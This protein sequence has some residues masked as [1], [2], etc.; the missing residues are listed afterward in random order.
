MWFSLHD[1]KQMS[2]WFMVRSD[3]SN[4]RSRRNIINLLFSNI[5]LL[6]FKKKSNVKNDIYIFSISFDLREMSL[7]WRNVTRS[8]WPTCSRNR[9]YKSCWLYS[10]WQSCECILEEKSYNEIKKK[11]LWCENDQTQM[12]ERRKA[13]TYWYRSQRGRLE[14]GSSSARSTFIPLMCTREK[15]R[16]MSAILTKSRSLK[17]LW[18]GRN[19]MNMHTC[20][21]I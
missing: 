10:V 4:L 16:I 7:T 19:V 20:T 15:S 8:A 6:F 18:H 5:K 9:R 11:W 14:K 12:T 1:F 21:V 13:W 2:I 3:F 17:I